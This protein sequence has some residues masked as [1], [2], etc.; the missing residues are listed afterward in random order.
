MAGTDWLTPQDG[1]G[2]FTSATAK[3][4]SV[5]LGLRGAGGRVEHPVASLFSLVE[6]CEVRSATQLCVRLTTRLGVAN[7]DCDVELRMSAPLA[8]GQSRCG[9]DG[10]EQF[11]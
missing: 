1:T 10:C 4:S 5:H 9:L 2:G 7:H 6:R 8:R 11:Q 3:S